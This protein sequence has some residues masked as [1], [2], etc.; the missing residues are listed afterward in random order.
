MF[1]VFELVS[2]IAHAIF[3]F[4]HD[5]AGF[6]FGLFCGAIGLSFVVV[7][8]L[9]YLAFSTMTDPA[10]ARVLVATNPGRICLLVGLTLEALA[11]GWMR[12]LVRAS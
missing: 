7:R 9:A 3:H 11:A 8:P 1:V 4:A 5:V 10:S 6:A 12:A 2:H